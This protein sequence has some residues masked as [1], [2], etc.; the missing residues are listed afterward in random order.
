MDTNKNTTKAKI[1]DIKIKK[2]IIG[3]SL[4]RVMSMLLGFFMVP[5]TLSYLDN[6]KYGIWLTLSSVIGWVVI[7]NIGLGSS[8]QNK[9][10]EAWANGDN[11]LART[12][13]STTY[14]LLIGIIL[15]GNIVFWLINPFLNW[16]EILNIEKNMLTE[17][18]PLVIIVF[19]FFT[20]RLVSNLITTILAADQR[21]A[22]SNFIAFL[23]SLLS[24]GIIYILTL[25]TNNSLILLGSS[26]CVITAVVPFIASIWFFKND[27]HTI[28]PSFKFIDFSKIKILFG[29]GIQFFLLQAASIILSMTDMIII[30]QLY[31]PDEVVPY[32]I[33]FKLFGYVIIFFGILTTPFWAA[34]NE[35]YNQHDFAWIERVTNK[36]LKIWVFVMLGVLLLI[37]ISGYIYH[38][39]IGDQVLIPKSLSLFMGIYVIIQT[40]NSIFSTFI[41]ATGKIRVLT[42]SAIF[43]G[44]INIPLCF[45]FAKTLEFGLS[46]IIMSTAVCALFNLTLGFIQYFKIIKNQDKGIWSK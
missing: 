16:A 20:F 9:L 18:N 5:L 22:L 34:Y 11:K 41:F 15:I 17:I 38:I 33:A 31:G 46:G 37:G 4:V 12:Y 32:N 29:Q 30:V 21:P 27:Y 1:R 36:L 28:S 13:V 42:I 26:L 8:L 23:A 6:T 2:N 19:S 43:V 40:M 45:I 35:A 14:A 25:T 7:L 39:W 3:L 24:F 44:T 10:G